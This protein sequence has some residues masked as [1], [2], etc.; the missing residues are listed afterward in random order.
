M[1]KFEANII[2]FKVYNLKYVLTLENL[3]DFSVDMHFSF[4]FS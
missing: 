3:Y 1:N 4:A 2:M